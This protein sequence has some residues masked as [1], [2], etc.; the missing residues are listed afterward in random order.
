MDER[1]FIQRFE[2]VEQIGSGAMG[3]VVRARDPQLEREVA[4][5]ILNNATQPAR[6][7]LASRRTINLRNDNAHDDLLHE[8]RIMARLAHPNVVPVYEVGLDGADVFVVMELVTGADLREWL[9]T[10][11]APDEI[12]SVLAQAGR[13]LAAAHEQGIVHRDFKPENV[14]IGRDGRVRVADFGLS[15]LIAPADRVL[16]VA[17]QGGT[18][19]YMAPELWRGE[20]ATTKSDVFAYCTVI[21]EMLADASALV[22]R[23]LADDP[24][25]R[26]DLAEVV[27]SLET[28]RLPRRRVIAVAALAIAAVAAGTVVY[29]LGSGDSCR[30][31]PALLGGR[32]DADIATAVQRALS[33]SPPG[34]AH[35]T[36]ADVARVLARVDARAEELRSASLDACR[37]REHD[38][39]S[40]P[41]HAVRNS[42]LERRAM[43]IGAFARDAVA[44]PPELVH[45]E[46]R[47]Q[48]LRPASVC[49]RIEVPPMTA[50]RTAVAA[51]YDRYAAND[52]E[53]NE[54]R[55]AVLAALE[56]EATALG[57][58]ELAVAAAIN[59]GI[60]DLNN[61]DYSASDAALARAYV[62][63]NDNHD[64]D[65]QALALVERSV[66]A[67][68]LGDFKQSR[69]YIDLAREI[70][71]RPTTPPR[72]SAL[73][74]AQLGRTE[75]QTG[76][77]APAVEHLRKAL[78][79][80][81]ASNDKMIFT[82]LSAQTDLLNYLTELREYDA[83]IKVGEDALAFIRD[84]LGAD[85][86]QYAVTLN[87]LAYPYRMQ[88]KHDE[89]IRYARQSLDLLGKLLPV[90]QY[91][92]VAGRNELMNGLIQAGHYQEVL[93]VGKIQLE[94]TEHK[95]ALRQL[96]PAAL[97]MIATAMFDLG[98]WD[99]AVRLLAR[100]TEEARE[101]FGATHPE[102]LYYRNELADLRI[103]VGQLADARLD[104]DEVERGW[105]AR[106]KSNSIKHAVFAGG[107]AARLLVAEG[108]PK[109]GEA[110]G[111]KA[112]GELAEL[113]GDD[114]SRRVILSTLAEAL[115]AQQ[116]WADGKEVLDQIVALSAKLNTIETYRVL[117]DV[118]AAQIEYG[119]GHHAEGLRI[120][121]HAQ[122]QLDATPTQPRARRQI[123]AFVAAHARE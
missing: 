31:D 64:T 22:E 115:V 8:A 57:E 72:V 44:G 4:I 105:R 78:A 54:R 12:A 35:L 65:Q 10:R 16:R 15:K 59:L 66:T 99:D 120:A 67:G 7:Q 20:P 6:D 46:E 76:D 79:I 52:R 110:L 111:R 75:G 102:T 101:V 56:R 61:D 21:R 36:P 122:Q 83:A 25:L 24:A 91:N 48:I 81:A 104:V 58:R 63:A 45:A 98:Q 53:P 89:A 121:R 95:P 17:D 68:R 43:E 113:H 73:V 96:R 84:N 114:D 26:P 112:L 71:D 37:A 90:D 34:P 103:D 86:R 92:V 27:R 29:I 94:A 80:V 77:H 38:E 123:D 33:A 62:Q 118:L 1:R 82:T 108:K 97:D 106:P 70:A 2:V 119:L 28:T 100:G 18:P 42:C 11:R 117:D 19:R 23:G 5:K 49:A 50:D 87:V 74:Y 32:W 107:T 51:L 9:E 13:G 85:S 40:A 14:L 41:Q 60:A 30:V 69:A 3:T 47:S 93:D 109:D 88:G 39:L 116:R 55:P